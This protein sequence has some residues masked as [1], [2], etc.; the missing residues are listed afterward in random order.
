MDYIKQQQA[1]QE[2]INESNKSSETDLI[3]VNISFFDF[4]F[5]IFLLLLDI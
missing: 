2:R 4:I 1:L 5:Q 3:D